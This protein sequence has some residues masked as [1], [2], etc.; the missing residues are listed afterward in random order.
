[1]IHSQEIIYRI[2]E[3]MADKPDY[4]FHPYDAP[5]AKT[6]PK[7]T[8]VW[9]LMVNSQRYREG[10]NIQTEKGGAVKIY[11]LEFIPFKGMN[12]LQVVAEA[13]GDLQTSKLHTEVI[14]FY[15]CE[16]ADEGEDTK[17]YLNL[18]DAK[19]GENFFVK[20]VKSKVN[21]V[22]V[23]CSCGDF[24]YRMAYDIDRRTKALATKLPNAIKNYKRKTPPP[25]PDGTGGMPFSNPQH[26]P[27]LCKHGIAILGKLN[28]LRII[29]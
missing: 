15:N 17:G 25:K 13:K 12:V 22:D 26:I 24:L 18:R 23:Y 27:G 6:Y 21:P 28:E 9:D 4:E 20:P 7:H 1:M 19:T 14:R 2:E 16:F 3:L 29:V 11:K 8:T 5:I 10:K